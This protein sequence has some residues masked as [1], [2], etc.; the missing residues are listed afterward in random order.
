MRTVL[1]MYCFEVD[2]NINIKKI[3]SEA[4]RTYTDLPKVL[5]TMDRNDIWKDIR[6]K[7]I[8]NVDTKTY[9]DAKF[10]S[11]KTPSNKLLI[12]SSGLNQ[13]YIHEIYDMQ[14]KAYKKE[15]AEKASNTWNLA[16]E[17]KSID[18]HIN[19]ISQGMELD[20]KISAKQ[21]N[22]IIR[23]K[24]RDPQIIAAFE[25]KEFD[26]MCVGLLLNVKKMSSI[27]DKTELGTLKVASI[28]GKIREASQSNT[29]YDGVMKEKQRL[30]KKGAK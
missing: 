14:M 4:F 22:E 6:E 3:T 7:L 18:Q 28:I 17:S 16:D 23:T 8:H 21:C 11:I 9:K 25:A 13:G 29:F 19:A 26:K 24:L 10:I 20:G 5:A 1:H 27:F 30:V 2:S 15:E 12:F